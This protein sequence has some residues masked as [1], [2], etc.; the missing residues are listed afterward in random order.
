MSKTER[1]HFEASEER[2]ELW[3][4]QSGKC[5]TCGR[6]HRNPE[7][8]EVAHKIANTRA[9]RGEYGTDVVGDRM[10]KAAVC[11]GG[12]YRGRSCNDAQ[13]VGNQPGTARALAAM[14]RARRASERTGVPV[15]V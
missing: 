6:I 5:A 12:M 11:R 7:S 10:N 3:R 8:M 9:N 2:L 14:I 4:E 1:Q 15:E 13:N